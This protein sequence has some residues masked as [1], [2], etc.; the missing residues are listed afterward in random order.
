MD[1]RTQYAHDYYLSLDK[2]NNYDVHVH[3][4]LHHFK[5]NHNTKNNIEYLFKKYKNVH[6]NVFSININ[7]DNP[8]K[9][10]KKIIK[11]FLIFLS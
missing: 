3:L 5:E 9:L 2:Y 1:T 4:I 7:N 11:D 8:K 10:V 6:S